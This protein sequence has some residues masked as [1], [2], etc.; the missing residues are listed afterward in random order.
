MLNNNGFNGGLNQVNAFQNSSVPSQN[1]SSH[2][3][4]SSA[5]FPN[6]ANKTPNLC[7]SMFVSNNNNFWNGMKNTNSNINDSTEGVI[8]S[9]YVDEHFNRGP[10]AH[11]YSSNSNMLGNSI[12]N[13]IDINNL[14]SNINFFMNNEEGRN[15]NNQDVLFTQVK[16]NVSI[17]GNRPKNSPL[18]NNVTR[19]NRAENRAENRSENRAENRSEYRG[20]YR[21]EYRGEYRGAKRSQSRGTRKGEI[22]SE[23]KNE[24]KN[25]IMNEI[26]NN[27]WNE[28]R[29]E[30]PHFR[31]NDFVSRDKSIFGNRLREGKFL[32]THMKN[33]NPVS[34]SM[35]DPNV[36]YSTN[37]NVLHVGN[38]DGSNYA[39]VN[40][41]LKNCSSGMY[42]ACNNNGIM[43][44]NAGI[45]TN[46]QNGLTFNAY[47]NVSS[48][49]LNGGNVN[50]SGANNGLFS[51]A[52]SC[53]PPRGSELGSGGF[54][55]INISDN[56][57]NNIHNPYLFPNSATNSEPM[58]VNYALFN[59]GNGTNIHA[60]LPYN[61]NESN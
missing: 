21:S 3:Q 29:N 23:F 59:G 37:A 8:N 56:F 1:S 45:V 28:G 9:M 4:N 12:N 42:S 44:K 19:E 26:T 32:F 11:D 61:H 34:L 31:F 43:A 6:R 38:Q 39:T 24:N 14:Q 46:A 22:K 53:L 2:I 57:P 5:L 48:S 16:Q 25:D 20:E 15:Y 41:D 33:V 54:N 13:N 17:F 55:S 50:G 27:S 47:D 36:N 49:N 18:F 35:N 10:L 51:N 30:S 40:Y 7:N 60:N 58:Q 52:H